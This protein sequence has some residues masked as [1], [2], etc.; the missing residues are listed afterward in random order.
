MTRETLS[1]PGTRVA[2]AVAVAAAAFAGRWLYLAWR[3]NRNG[4]CDDC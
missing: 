1:R 3:S 4:G 2:L